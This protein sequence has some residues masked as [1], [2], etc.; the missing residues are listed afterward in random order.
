MD[1]SKGYSASYYITYVDPST[2][3]DLKR[4]EVSSGSINRST[5]SLRES[6]SI[7][8][9]QSFTDV[10]T[11]IRI[12]MDID[13]NGE[14]IH[15]PLFT[16][17]ATSPSLEFNGNIQT[18]TYECYSVLKPVDD[19][20]LLRGWYIN[21]G[22]S[23]A[24]V[25]KDLLKITSAP[26][27]IPEEFSGETSQYIKDYIIAEDGDTNLSMIDKILSAIKWR[28]RI[29]GDGSI[30]IEPSYSIVKKTKQYFDPLGFD[31]IE[32]SIK[33]SS[34]WFSVPNVFCAISDGLYAVAK[35][36][37]PNS[38]LSIINRGRE[39]WVTETNCNLA[40]G[41]TIES[42]AKDRLTEEQMVAKTASYSRRYIPDLVPGDV[43]N[44]SYPKQQLDGDFYISDQ[45][46]DLGYS[47]R[48]N[49][50]VMT[51]AR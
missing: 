19:V 4:V 13:Q 49:E 39:V 1:W 2:W 12:Y 25:V 14:R 29:K 42:Y 11:W 21:A 30:T 23:G 40:E 6:A 37:D 27:S 35:D 36:E 47:A 15:E 24:E 48:T 33:V 20:A 22:S 9:K 41:T 3:C 44:L 45:S 16:G 26:V 43:V 5:D 38:K 10:E 31:I 17:L 34:D 51:Y 46:I 8:C 50:E 18:N 7:T 28:L 32:P